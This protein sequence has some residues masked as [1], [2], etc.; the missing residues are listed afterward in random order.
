MSGVYGAV[1]ATDLLN[2]L[3][4]VNYY[5]RLHYQEYKIIFKMKSWLDFFIM[6]F[7]FKKEFSSTSVI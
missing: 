2:I 1:V 7:Y 3:F 6:E 5:L 4:T